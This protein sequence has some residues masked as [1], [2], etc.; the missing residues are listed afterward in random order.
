M[1]HLL[2]Y[3][4]ELSSLTCRQWDTSKFDARP[5]QRRGPTITELPLG[6]KVEGSETLEETTST[7]LLQL[8]V[9]MNGRVLAEP[10]ETLGRPLHLRQLLADGRILTSIEHVQHFS[11][12]P[13]AVR[14]A[15]G[16]W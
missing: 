2:H 12:R 3:L 11:S 14:A 15:I 7:L 16:G 13:R 5:P 8:G 9:A 10:A 4:T 6:A 1:F